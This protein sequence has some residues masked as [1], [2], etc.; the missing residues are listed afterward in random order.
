MIEFQQDLIRQA[1][2]CGH[3]LHTG[4]PA[5]VRSRDRL[6]AGVEGFPGPLAAGC[7]AEHRFHHE[8]YSARSPVSPVR[9]R[10][11]PSR[12]D[13]KIFPSP[14]LPVLAVRMIVST[15]LSVRASE[16]TTS[17]LV[18]GTNSIVYSVPR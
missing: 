10:T 3:N 17:I 13:T 11:T 5:R 16:T 6:P 1:G 4:C 12:L 14:M 2:Q 18:L 15:T 7:P 9:I 8:H